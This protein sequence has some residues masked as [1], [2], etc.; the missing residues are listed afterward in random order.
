LATLAREGTAAL[1]AYLLARRISTPPQAGAV[2]FGI[3]VATQLAQTLDASWS[4]GNLNLPVLAAVSG[5]TAFLISTLTL[6]PSRNLLD[7]SLPTS[8]GWL[9]I[10]GGALAAA[11]LS[12]LIAVAGSG[13]SSE[14]NGEPCVELRPTRRRELEHW[15]EPEKSEFSAT[16][17]VPG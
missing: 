1:A 4:E 16:D 7:L 14:A 13:W 8:A 2:A 5:S 15:I 9:P 6:N 12:R 11:A 17:Q 10:G 3:I